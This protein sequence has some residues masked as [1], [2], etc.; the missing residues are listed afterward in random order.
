MPFSSSLKYV[1]AIDMGSGSA[2]VAVVSSAGE[3]VASALRPTTTKIMAGGAVERDPEEWCQAVCEA[4]REAIAASRVPVQQIIPV[5]CTTQWAVTVAVDEGGAAIGNAIS[6]MDTRG[7][8]VLVHCY[9][10]FWF[11]IRSRK[12]PV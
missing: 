11:L 2:K 1:L 7:A 10:F 12:F 8:V 4:A 5:A 6:W 9:L 3:V